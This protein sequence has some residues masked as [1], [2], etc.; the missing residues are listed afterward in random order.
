MYIF[1]HA[2]RYATEVQITI[3]ADKQVTKKD[4]EFLLKLTKLLRTGG[5][6]GNMHTAFTSDTCWKGNDCKKLA[7]DFLQAAGLSE[8]CEPVGELESEESDESDPH[9]CGEESE[10][11]VGD[12]DMGEDEE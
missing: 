2:P 1:L 4:Q 12:V 3:A 5:R 7:R 6:Y 10:E 9:S 8:K 11:S